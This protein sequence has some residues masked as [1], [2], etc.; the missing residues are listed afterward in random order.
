MNAL[1]DRCDVDELPFAFPYGCPR[2]G[3]CSSPLMDAVIDNGLRCGLT[4]AS[5]TNKIDTSPFGWGRFHV[6]EHDTP[7]SLAARLDGWYEWLPKTKD[8]LTGLVR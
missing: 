2:Q 8:L 7:N 5:Q 6:F 4:T 1:Q 3:F